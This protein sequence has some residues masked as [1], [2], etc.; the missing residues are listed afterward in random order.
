MEYILEEMDTE[1]FSRVL[2]R[3]PFLAECVKAHLVREFGI[4]RDDEDGEVQIRHIAKMLFRLVQIVK[5]LKIDA[6]VKVFA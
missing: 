1:E 5:R 4:T 2:D 3:T 6:E